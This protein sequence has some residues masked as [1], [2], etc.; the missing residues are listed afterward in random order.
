MFDSIFGLFFV[1]I[2]VALTPC[3]LPILPITYKTLSY[4][5]NSLIAVINYTIGM[6]ISYA[7]IGLLVALFGN[8]F[9]LQ[10]TLQKPLFTIIIA[11]LFV[12]LGLT[13]FDISFFKIGNYLTNLANK[14]LDKIQPDK[15]YK[16]FVIGFMSAFLL[17]PCITAPLAGVLIYIAQSNDLWMGFWGLFSLGI[18]MGLP[19]ILLSFGLNKWIPKSPD[20]M[21]F[22]KQLIGFIMIAFGIWM[23][24]RVYA[25]DLVVSFFGMMLYIGLLGFVMAEILKKNA[26]FYLSLLIASIISI[27]F[28]YTEGYFIKKSD[29]L[30]EHAIIEPVELDHFLNNDNDK[31]IFVDFYASW[32]A[33]CLKMEKTIFYN[34]QTINK[35]DN[36]LIFTQMDV[37]NTT[38]SQKK[39]MNELNIYGPPAIAIFSD[40]GELL[41]IKYGE[42]SPEEFLEWINSI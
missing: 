27:L 38:E 17:S 7:L 8:Q 11:F 13:M 3:V 22:I 5:N 31:S 41:D 37:T 10:I 2:L 30:I 19:I 32:C 16:V 42:L 6:S 35:I 9:N 39:F 12:I 23:V 14:I 4:K 29:S 33:P 26:I 40:E 28:L 20:T 36:D 18:G 24:M 15:W 1:G 21:I 34:Q 25:D